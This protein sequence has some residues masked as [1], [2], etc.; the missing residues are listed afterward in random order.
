MLSDCHV[1]NE[2]HGLLYRVEISR[3]LLV[4][5]LDGILVQS[6]VQRPVQVVLYRP[7]LLGVVMQ[8]LGVARQACYVEP[9]LVTRLARPLVDCV[10]VNADD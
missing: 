9:R 2:Q 4:L 5:A 7:V 8:R 6:C 10:N 1:L 3:G